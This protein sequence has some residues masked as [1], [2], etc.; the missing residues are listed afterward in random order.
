MNELRVVCSHLIP[1]LVMGVGVWDDEDTSRASMPPTIA[2]HWMLHREWREFAGSG[3]VRGSWH[4]DVDMLFL[5]MLSCHLL[6]RWI[7]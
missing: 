2:V 4:V 5:Q 6:M 3:S 7:L 1:A